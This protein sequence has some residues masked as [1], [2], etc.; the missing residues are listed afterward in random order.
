MKKES[1]DLLMLRLSAMYLDGGYL[2]EADELFHHHAKDVVYAW[3]T[4][5]EK[6]NY[7]KS[8]YIWS[9]KMN[10]EQAR[11]LVNVSGP[12]LK[13]PFELHYYILILRKKLLY[14]LLLITWF[15]V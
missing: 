4:R 1:E 8:M 14:P 13:S 12:N 15:Y 3:L 7:L 6:L 10:S 9:K 2:Y 5:K 11:H